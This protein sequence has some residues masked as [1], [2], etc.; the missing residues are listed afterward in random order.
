M[1]GKRSTG[2]S[3]QLLSIDEAGEKKERHAEERDE[4]ELTEIMR[5]LKGFLLSFSTE[6][7]E[8]LAGVRPFD[9]YVTRE[10]NLGDI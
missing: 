1:I 9:R 6:I 2:Q 7:E 8:P 3:Q 10:W 5:K 4:S